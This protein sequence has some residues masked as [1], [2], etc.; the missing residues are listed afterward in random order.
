MPKGSKKKTSPREG[1]QSSAQTRSATRSP[2]RKGALPVREAA[3]DELASVAGVGH[4]SD[5]ELRGEMATAGNSDDG[6]PAEND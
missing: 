2:K 5:R 3:R 4:L 6:E 1:Q